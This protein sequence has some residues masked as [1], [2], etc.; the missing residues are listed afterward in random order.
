MWKKRKKLYDI[1][2]QELRNYPIKIQ[3][4]H[5]YD[6]KHGYHLFYLFLIQKI[7]NKKN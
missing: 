4:N 2:Y 6:F 1:Y 5:K 7:L 3:N